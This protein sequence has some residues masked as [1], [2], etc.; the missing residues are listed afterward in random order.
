MQLS[1]VIEHILFQVNTLQQCMKNMLGSFTKHRHI[2]HAGYTFAGKGSWILQVQI[3]DSWAK[4]RRRIRVFCPQ[5]GTY[6]FADFCAAFEEYDV[7]RVVRSYENSISISVHCCQ[8][9]DWNQVTPHSPSFQTFM[10]T[11]PQQ[12][13]VQIL[14]NLCFGQGQHKYLMQRFF[15]CKINEIFHIWGHKKDTINQRRKTQQGKKKFPKRN[16]TVMPQEMFT[17][18]VSG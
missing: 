4:Y 18:L 5:D 17:P 11:N 7:Q 3:L 2:I 13:V 1:S 10:K 14:A 15:Y 9:G 8:E 6:S 12:S 16:Y